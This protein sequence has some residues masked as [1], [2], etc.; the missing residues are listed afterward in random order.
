MGPLDTIATELL[1]VSPAG[2]CDHHTGLHMRNLMS[3]KDSVVAIF[4][5]HDTAEDAIR[6]P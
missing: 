6:E 2:H 4:D 1:T 5:S 3:D